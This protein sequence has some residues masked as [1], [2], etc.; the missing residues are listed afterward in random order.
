MFSKEVA[1]GGRWGIVIFFG[2]EQGVMGSL[3]VFKHKALDVLQQESRPQTNIAFDDTCVIQVFSFCNW[4]LSGASPDSLCTHRERSPEPWLVI[5]S[6]L[7]STSALPLSALIFSPFSPPDNSVT[8][9]WRTTTW[10]SI[11][12]DLWSEYSFHQLL[13]G[14]Y[15][16]PTLNGNIVLADY[17]REYTVSWLLKVI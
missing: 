3:W 10:E 16:S 2:R 11:F 7:K 12:T 8:L 14:I 1:M 5:W 4:N 9:G 17:S 15:C 6:L 13:K